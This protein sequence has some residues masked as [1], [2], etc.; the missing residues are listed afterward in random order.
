MT[1]G[2]GTDTAGKVGMPI[3]FTTGADDNPDGCVLIALNQTNHGAELEEGVHYYLKEIESPPGYQIDSSV[4]FWEFTLTTDPDEVCY[5]TERDEYNNRKWIYFY[6][7]DVLK[8]NNTETEEP[9][10]VRVDKKWYEADGTL[11]SDETL[12]NSNYEAE[13]Q[14]Y[15]K[16]NNEDYAAVD[17]ITNSDGEVLQ[18]KITLPIRQDDDSIS[19]V[20]N[21]NNLPRVD[22]EGNKYA[23]KLEETKVQDGFVS[24]TD[25]KETENEKVYRIGNYRAA[26]TKIAFKVTKAWYDE[27]GETPLTDDENEN[28]PDYVDFQLFRVV[29]REPYAVRPTSGGNPYIIES[30]RYYQPNAEK[31]G[32]YRIGKALYEEGIVLGEGTN[33]QLVSVEEIDGI[34]YYYSY[35]VKELPVPGYNSALQ[36]EVNESRKAQIIRR[37]SRR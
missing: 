1:W 32:T 24:A 37:S 17:T 8:M 11:I 31:E 33:N 14:L 26:E 5:G 20:Y 21:W 15:Q 18:G 25:V 30:S 6:Y 28:L 9:I 4:E 13:F 29:S 7:N 22:T 2:I 19:W 16:Q 12:I 27:D 35:Y 36:Q 23:Y 34:W 3:T 10:S